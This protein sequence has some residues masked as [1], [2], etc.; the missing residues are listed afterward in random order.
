MKVYADFSELERLANRIGQAARLDSKASKFNREKLAMTVAT[1]QLKGIIAVAEL[2]ENGSNWYNYEYEKD[3]TVAHYFLPGRAHVRGTWCRGWV[4]INNSCP[5]FG[6]G[7]KP[8]ESEIKTKVELTPVVKKGDVYEILLHN[9]APYA[10]AVEH[11]HWVRLPYFMGPDGFATPRGQGPILPRPVPGKYWTQR[12]I[13]R[14]EDIII[15]ETR[16]ETCRM[17]KKVVK[18]R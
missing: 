14:Y 4:S 7:K 11:G 18:G 9:N 12:A 16:N 3:D 15:S 17:L 5:D 1:E 6:S 13:W 2:G 8:T 10:A